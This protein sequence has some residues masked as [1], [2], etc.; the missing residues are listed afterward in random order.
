MTAVPDDVLTV[1]GLTVHRG[2]RRILSGVDLTVRRGSVV[3]VVGPNGAGKSTLLSCLYR[4]TAYQQGQVTVDGRELRTLPR[5][6]L[7]R[8]I[9]AVPQD[10]PI[11]FDLTVEDIV[12]AGRIPHTGALG[13]DRKRDRDVITES[14]RRVNLEQLRHRSAATLSGG[15]RQRAFLGRALAQAAPVLILDEPTNHLDLANQEQLL[16]LVRAHTGTT[17][18]AIHDLNLAAEYCDQIVVLD[19]GTVVADGPVDEVITADLLKRVFRVSA[20]VIA[21]PDS[22][23]P[24]IVPAARGGSR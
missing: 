20:H 11:V 17:L 5:R 16:G 13:M 6:E 9:A 24:H 4:H 21:H 18:V 2:G 8:V 1:R 10:T 3:G 12:A 19:A 23:R 14:L 22:G 15:E 7:A